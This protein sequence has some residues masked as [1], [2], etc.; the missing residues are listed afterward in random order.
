MSKSQEG[1]S[2]ICD[3]ESFRELIENKKIDNNY[4]LIDLENYKDNFEEKKF[5]IAIFKVP[6]KISDLLTY[7]KNDQISAENKTK[8]LSN[9]NFFL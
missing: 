4:Y 5:N 2:L 8:I 7:I 6:I 1:C 3:N 9:L